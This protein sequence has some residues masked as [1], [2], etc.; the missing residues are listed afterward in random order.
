MPVLAAISGIVSCLA[1]DTSEIAPDFT[2]ISATNF[3]E[4]FAV[5]ETV[6]PDDYVLP[7]LDSSKALIVDPHGVGGKPDDANPGTTEK[8]FAT[9]ARAM[10]DLKPGTVILLRKGL[11]TISTPIQIDGATGQ[12]GS[13][14]QP[15]VVASFPGEVASIVG[16]EPVREWTRHGET[17]LYFHDCEVPLGEG[18]SVWVDDQLLP[19]IRRFLHARNA[20]SS[21]KD[22]SHK[23]LDG[24]LAV[25]EPGTWAMEGKRLWLRAPNDADPNT[26]RVEVHTLPATMAGSIVFK[27]SEQVHF[28]RVAFRKHTQAIVSYTSPYLVFRECLFENLYY[29]ITLFGGDKAERGIVDRCCFE[30]IGD[31]IKGTP[32]YVTAPV[33][34]RHGLFRDVSPCISVTAYTSKPDM[35]TGLKVIG[36]TFLHGGACITSTGKGSVVR[37]N[38]ALGSRFLSSAGSDAVIE[39]NLAM[40]DPLDLSVNPSIPRR[41]IGFRLY[42]KNSRFANNTLV[43]FHDGGAIYK[44][45]SGDASV[46][47]VS[48]RFVGYENYALRVFDPASLRGDHNIFVPASTNACE[49]YVTLDA[50]NKVRKSLAEW[51]AE[52]HDS[53]SVTTARS[54]GAVPR[55]IEDALRR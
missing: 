18:T 30:R 9:L 17:P 40:Y 10:K 31:S 6:S 50:T 3:F 45:E 46:L 23:R 43:G 14:E 19:S 42:G 47:V 54:P 20:G 48:N 35:F 55:V 26:R 39:N 27:N 34:V 12:K 8:P 37:D 24:N 25:T 22:Q 28:H 1:A 38:I 29:A 53:N 11:H 16:A 36:N 13:R 52:G 21:E 2:G 7:T 44:P 4:R 33:T 15:A 51:Q 32:L 41:D 49:V 5:G